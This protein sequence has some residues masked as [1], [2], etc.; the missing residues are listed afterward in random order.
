M[1]LNMKNDFDLNEKI[2]ILKKYQFV[3]SKFIKNILPNLK[4]DNFDDVSNAIPDLITKI[5]PKYFRA[6][7]TNV[8]RYILAYF[9]KIETMSGLPSLISLKHID[10]FLT[11]SQLMKFLEK[12]KPE[13]DQGVT[14]IYPH[15]M[16]TPIQRYR[17]KQKPI[18][19]EEIQDFTKLLDIIIASK[20]I[21]QELFTAESIDDMPLIS[22]AIK[23][24]SDISINAYRSLSKIKTI[25]N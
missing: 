5:D 19:L 16:E 8:N 9:K 25:I 13:I 2:D 23:Q 12:I 1:P 21:Q 20:S 17:H 10:L 22:R 7:R 11:K 6:N 3:A 18:L 15:A 4:N 24:E 14:I